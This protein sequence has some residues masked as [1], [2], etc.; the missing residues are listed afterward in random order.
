MG[1]LASR[2]KR[3]D[4]SESVVRHR[5]KGANVRGNTAMQEK[6]FYV[7]KEGFATIV[8]PKCGKAKPVDV[9][10]LPPTKRRLRVQCKCG[11]VFRAHLEIRKQYR[12]TVELAGSY[13]NRSRDEDS[14]KVV[15]KDI[16][17]GGVGF[18]TLRIHDIIK[19]DMLDLTL[20]L[21]TDP[22]R[23]ITRQVR[24]V[25]VSGH[26][27]GGAFAQPLERDPDLG[28]YLMA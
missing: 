6:T 4:S 21:D 1:D 17:L 5:D 13:F 3:T 25:R 23:E 7:N 28:F 24:V 14:G 9:K 12:K 15:V 27:I 10:Q 22:P 16:S 18:E 20:T 2:L 11:E 19:G 8:C 26:N